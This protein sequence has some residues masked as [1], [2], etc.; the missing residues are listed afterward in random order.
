MKRVLSTSLAMALLFLMTPA[1]A[2]VFERDWKTPGDGLLTY[3]DVNQREWLDFSVSRLDQFPEPRVGNAIAQIS[4]GGIFDGFTW[5]TRQ[6]VIQ[7]AQSAGVDTTTTNF[8]IN[9]SATSHLITL[10]GVSFQNANTMRSIGFID[11]IDGTRQFGADFYIAFNSIT[12]QGSQAGLL[13]SASDDFLHL[14]PQAGLMLYRIVPEPSSLQFVICA[15]SSLPLRR[16]RHR[17][18]ATQ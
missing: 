17:T 3:D 14:A 2:A 8:A 18:K 1:R 4:P 12:G 10:L 11:E 9:Q 13:V 5:A 15:L 6:D 7:F 16:H